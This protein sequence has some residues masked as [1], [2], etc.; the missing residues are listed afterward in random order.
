MSKLTCISAVMVVSGLLAGCDPATTTDGTGESPADA[1]STGSNTAFGTAEQGLTVI[2]SHWWYST[3]ASTVALGSASDRVCFLN[4]MTGDFDLAGNTIGT[5]TLWGNWYLGGSADAPGVGALTRCVSAT[6]G[7]YTQEY[8]WSQGNPAV[9]LG[10][11]NGRVCFL[12]QVQGNFNGGAERVGTYLSGGNWYLG[13]NS[14]TAGVGA[15]ARCVNASSYS[16]EYSWNQS[17][18]SPPIPTPTGRSFVPMTARC[19]GGSRTSRKTT[20]SGS[21]T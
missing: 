12:T 19:S 1:L 15:K 2:N 10:S 7:S 6:A 16:G 9:N 20:C 5:T 13:G 3:T 11:G 8:S 17:M 18:S 4:K 14:Q 21:R